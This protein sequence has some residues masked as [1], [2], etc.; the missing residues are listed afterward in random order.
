MSVDYSADWVENKARQ[1]DMAEALVLTSMTY[2]NLFSAV[3]LEA[4][5]EAV[6][7]QEDR[8]EGLI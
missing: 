2:L 6:E 8:K 1:E 5:L 4:V 7:L 3:A